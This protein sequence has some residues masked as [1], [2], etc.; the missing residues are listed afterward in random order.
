[1]RE[2]TYGVSARGIASFFVLSIALVFFVSGNFGSFKF[3]TGSKSAFKVPIVEL[4]TKLTSASDEFQ[5]RSTTTNS[6]RNR[7]V[8]REKNG[9]LEHGLARA[10]ALIRTA[11]ALSPNMLLTLP[12]GDGDVLTSDIYHNYG[13]FYHDVLRWE[14]FSVQVETQKIPQLK[15]VL[16]GISEEKYMRLKEGVRAVRR[17]FVWNQPAKSPKLTLKVSSS[18]VCK[19]VFVKP[20]TDIEGL[21]IAD[22][23]SQRTLSSL[24]LP[25]AV[26]VATGPSSPISDGGPPSYENQ[27]RTEV[28]TFDGSA[29][30]I[31]HNGR[32]RQKFQD[33]AQ[34]IS[35]QLLEKFSLVTAFAR[36]TT[37]QLF[38]DSNSD[39]FGAK[40]RRN[41][42]QTPHPYPSIVASNDVEEVPNEIPI[43]L[44][45][46]ELEGEEAQHSAKKRLEREKARRGATADMS[47]HLSAGEKG[48][49][50][51]HMSAHGGNTR[52][53]MPRI[54]SVD[55]ME[56]WA[57]QHKEKKLYIVLIRHVKY[58]VELARALGEMPGV[59]Q[60]DL[61][62]RQV[63][64]P[65]VGWSYGEPTEMLNSRNLENDIH[66]TGES[67][68]AYIIRIPFGPKDKYIPK[69]LL[70]PHISEFVDGA[71]CHIIQMSRVRGEQIGGMEP[72]WPVAIH[73]HYADAGDSAALLSGALNVPMF[74]TGHSLGRDKLEQLLKQGRQS[75]DEINAAYKIM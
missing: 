26:A 27:E 64:A 37:S 45:P 14:G 3:F 50:V 71:L 36:E 68:G 41:H 2:A 20:Q 16:M 48:E 58:V 66:E 23:V 17:H 57:N 54:S 63:S 55:A 51:V 33:P 34:D 69:E 35:I 60:I 67:S 11:A 75:R 46:L 8:I 4:Q 38:R 13:E 32:P 39:V 49:V 65:D 31:Q 21:N 61:L 6:F 22:D 62:T 18:I 29:S 1:M 9:G 15:E 12:D 24:E 74:F 28:G 72:V 40:Q 42:D 5:A 43:A 52:G 56:N 44:D 73:G 53:R 19:V 70:W 59:Y 10:R 30:L 47:E 25:R 7:T